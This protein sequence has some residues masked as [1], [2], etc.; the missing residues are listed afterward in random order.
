VRTISSTS[1]NQNCP[2]DYSAAIKGAIR[3]QA[4]GEG[5]SN[6]LR[7]LTF[8]AC[9]PQAAI[10]YDP[11]TAEPRCPESTKSRARRIPISQSR[12]QKKYRAAPSGREK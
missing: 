2:A 6:A 10:V 4:D 11:A 1:D 8:D 3:Y 5:L 7:A 12:S 9:A